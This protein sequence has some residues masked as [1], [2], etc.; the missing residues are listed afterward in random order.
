[1]RYPDVALTSDDGEIIPARTSDPPARP[2]VPRE[3]EDVWAQLLRSHEL[4]SWL[5]LGLGRDDEN[6]DAEIT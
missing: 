6:P 5:A 4:S 1:L 2:D 3:G